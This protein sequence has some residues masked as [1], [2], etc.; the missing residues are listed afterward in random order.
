M[1]QPPGFRD[2]SRPD[3]VCLLR[4]SLYG[5]KQAPRAWYHRFATYISSIG[6]R[7]S[8]SDNSLFIHTS[9]SQT[10]YL[11]LYIDDIALIASSKMFLQQI[12]SALKAEFDMTD[13]GPL[14][15]FLGIAVTRTSSG[16]FLSQEKYATKIICKSGMTACK[17]LS[18]PQTRAP[19]SVLPLGLL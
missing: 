4:K 12:I 6:F 13:L 10:A 1:H 19:N 11:L 18:T 17:P 3:H 2:R 14:N 9:G 16:M 8:K 7:S 5:L 15:Y